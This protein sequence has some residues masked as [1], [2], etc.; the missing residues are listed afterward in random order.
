MTFVQIMMITSDCIQFDKSL[1]I[2][3]IIIINIWNHIESKAQCV[4]FVVEIQCS[5]LKAYSNKVLD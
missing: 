4:V 1:I 3:I 2:I 5:S